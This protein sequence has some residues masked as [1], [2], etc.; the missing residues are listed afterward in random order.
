M[1][2]FPKLIYMKLTNVTAAK[3]FR[4]VV[5]QAPNDVLYVNANTDEEWTRQ[6]VG[7]ASNGVRIF[8]QIFYGLIF[9]L[10]SCA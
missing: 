4:S 7:R 9:L 3:R 1:T 8:M 10:L 2:I 6:Q 5:A